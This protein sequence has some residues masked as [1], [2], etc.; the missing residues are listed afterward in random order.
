M[1]R[2]KDRVAIITGAGRGIG[3]ETAQLFADHGAT[4]IVCDLDEAA[5]KD[6]EDPTGTIRSAPRRGQPLSVLGQR[7]VR[8]FILSAAK[9]AY[10]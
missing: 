5:G 9:T 6:T 1:M 7:R 8:L 10:F 4:V 2:L 3:H